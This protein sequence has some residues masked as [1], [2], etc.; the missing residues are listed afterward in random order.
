[1]ANNW[2]EVEQFFQK[3][4]IQFEQKDWVYLCHLNGRQFYYSPQTGKWRL[5]GERA[6]QGSQNLADF[7]HQALNYFSTN[8][9]A[10]QSHNHS[11]Q[12]RQQTSRQQ[13]KKTSKT[14]RKQSNERASSSKQHFHEQTANKIRPE[15]VESFGQFLKIQRVKGYKIG[16]IFYALLDRLL[17][18]PIEICWLCVVF[19]Y[20]SG[21]AFYQIKHLYGHADWEAILTLI[22]K[23]Q[24]QWLRDYE[25]RWGTQTHRQHQRENKSDRV[26]NSQK[27][28]GAYQSYLTILNIS[29]PFTKGELKSAYRKMALLTHPDSGGC[30]EAFRQ[31]NSAYQVLLGFSC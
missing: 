23:N 8:E 16:W 25:A 17:P 18:T 13:T 29:F 21:W 15:F 30:A 26:N 3:A 20:A 4:G 11:Q 27:P 5:K 24:S 10:S 14:S 28:S 9:S 19:K 12:A 2:V 6:W 1:V 31:V 22:E 7:L